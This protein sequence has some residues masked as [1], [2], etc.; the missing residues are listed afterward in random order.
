MDETLAD[1][2]YGAGSLAELLDSLGG[3]SPKRVR[4]QPAPGTATV[5][6]VIRLRDRT[7]RLY[8]LV[9]AT[10]V[11][12]VMGAPES[13]IEAEVSFQLKAWNREHG[14]PGMVLG[15]EGR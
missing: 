9:E 11:E 7:R 10:L 3:I 8:E 14:N 15:A 12:K 6:D 5:D 2:E 1:L 13:F 4:L